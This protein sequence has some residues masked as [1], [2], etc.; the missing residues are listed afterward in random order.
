VLK[1]LAVSHGNPGI[2]FPEHRV[3]K[4]C[5]YAGLVKII[6]DRE[7]SYPLIGFSYQYLVNRRAAQKLNIANPPDHVVIVLACN[8]SDT[9]IFDPF[10]AR[11]RAMQASS[12]R[13]G[14][15]LY[16]MATSVMTRYWENAYSGV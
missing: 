1:E 11:S 8:Q 16:L 15:G 10:D 5:D 14:R 6:G 9:I 13:I 2:A 7:S 4:L 3:N 12:G